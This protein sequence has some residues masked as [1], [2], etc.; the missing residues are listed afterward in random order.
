MAYDEGVAESVRDAFSGNPRIEEKRMFG[1]L[2]FMLSGN[3]CCGVIGDELMA[4]VGPEQYAAA[5][6][7][8]QCDIDVCSWSVSAHGKARRAANGISP[9]LEAQRS[10]GC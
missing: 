8:F 10:H 5:L 1:G 2:A 3:M 6:V 4:R 9:L 7:L